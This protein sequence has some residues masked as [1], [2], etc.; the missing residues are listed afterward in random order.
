[1][2]QETITRSAV[3]LSIQRALLGEVSSALR[4][5]SV[6]W[7]HQTI[8]IRSYFDSEISEDDRESMSSVQTEVLADFPSHGV[9]MEIIRLDVPA[10]LPQGMFIY[11]RRESL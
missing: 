10:E 7:D 2:M 9:N 1:M 3:F 5:V 4:G 6:D 11:V 8:N